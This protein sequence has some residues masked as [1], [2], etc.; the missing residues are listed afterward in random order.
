MAEIM[1]ITQAGAVAAIISAAQ[2]NA[3]V[4]RLMP[5]GNLGVVYGTARWIGGRDPWG[6]R[7]FTAEDHA[8][9]R[10]L[11]LIVRTDRDPDRLSAWQLCF[12][13]GEYL[14]GT[15]MTDVTR[16]GTTSGTGRDH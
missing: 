15:F 9:V 4:A 11:Y 14:A 6:P 12:L 13:I 7:D 8:D 1:T 16:D 5:S 3:P 2:R 10:D